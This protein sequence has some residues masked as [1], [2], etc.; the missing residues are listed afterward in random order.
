MGS[1]VSMVGKNLC[2]HQHLNA[3]SKSFSPLFRSGRL[4]RGPALPIRQETSPKT[5]IISNHLG[6]DADRRLCGVRCGIWCMFWCMFVPEFRSF[7]CIAL[8]S[9][10]MAYILYIKEICRFM[11]ERATHC[12]MRKIRLKIRRPSGHGGSPPLPASYKVVV[13]SLI[14]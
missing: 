6:P 11:R 7:H 14:L 2:H 13:I 3:L 1:A 8:Q 12:K 5:R 9:R 4:I 10:S